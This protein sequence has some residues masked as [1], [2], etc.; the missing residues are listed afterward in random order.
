MLK[1]CKTVNLFL[2]PQC[3]DVSLYEMFV[4]DEQVGFNSVLWVNRS[5]PVLIACRMA[6]ANENLTMK[7]IV[8]S[9]IYILDNAF[10]VHQNRDPYTFLNYTLTRYDK[11]NLVTTY[12]CVDERKPYA[13]NY[14]QVTISFT[15]DVPNTPADTLPPPPTNHR[16]ITHPS[17]TPWPSRQL[18]TIS[19]R[20]PRTSK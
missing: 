6:V 11:W 8:G 4:N 3:A 18:L 12:R 9:R 20:L 13:P 5:L 7:K 2:H 1:Y 17:P 10:T 19:P 15:F 16:A 14:A